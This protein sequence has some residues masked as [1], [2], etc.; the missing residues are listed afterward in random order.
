M[1]RGKMKNERNLN[2]KREREGERESKDKECI[3]IFPGGIK[4][5]IM[6][7][8]NEHLYLSVPMFGSCSVCDVD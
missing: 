4:F 6:S 1:M 3:I 2:F 5:E 8:L 7:I